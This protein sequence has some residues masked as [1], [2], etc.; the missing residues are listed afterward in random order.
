MPE[1]ARRARLYGAEG[2]GLTR[3]EHMFLGERR[4]LVEA[5]V[6]AETDEERQAALDALLPCNGPIST[7]SSRRW[8]GS[9]SPCA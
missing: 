5:M 9:P 6:L 2:I 1:D 4:K 8:T 7:P 3:T